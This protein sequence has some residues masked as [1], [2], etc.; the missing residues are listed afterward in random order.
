MI[1]FSRFS[2]VYSGDEEISHY[3]L[4]ATLNF[5]RMHSPVA[6]GSRIVSDSIDAIPTYTGRSMDV[7]CASLL[8]HH[9]I[10]EDATSVELSQPNAPLLK[11]HSTITNHG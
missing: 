9:S 3:L 10:P 2:N 8:S 4:F 5:M 11:V 1:R 7:F 6:T